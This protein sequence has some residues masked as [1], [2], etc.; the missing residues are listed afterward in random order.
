M[1]V[2][3][4]P[5]GRT[6]A[7]AGIGKT[8]TMALAALS[9]PMFATAACSGSD[10]AAEAETARGTLMTSAV[11]AAY[12]EAAAQQGRV[13]VL[14]YEARDYTRTDG[15]VTQK[16]AYVYLPYGYTPSQRYD[17]IYL[18]HGWTGTA[19]QYF[20]LPTMPQMKNLFDHMI[21]DGVCRPFIAVSPTWDKDNRAKG[22]NEST[23][24]IAVFSQEYEH[25]LIPAIESHYST[26]AASTD[27]AGIEASRSHRAFGGF[28]LG[29]ITTWY[30]FEQA[31]SLQR[32]FLPMSGDNWHVAMFGGATRPT[33]TAAFLATVVDA[34]PFKSDF[35]VWH[36]VGSN[37]SRYAQS[38]NQAQ[39][40]MQLPEFGPEV[41]SYHERE[42]G[43]HDFYSVWEF[44]YNALPAFFPLHAE[45]STG[46]GRTP[47]ADGQSRR[48]AY[49]LDGR[50]ATPH[51]GAGVYVV[52]GRK[53]KF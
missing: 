8:L 16:P 19:E 50:R 47:Q 11:P 25:D 17:I 21:A 46:V 4:K 23:R 24:E 28:S 9:L 12:F 32:Y 2:E 15:A 51:D 44:C 31:F 42:G 35:H 41:Y 29:A 6:A 26:Y 27:R 49:T 13:E 20:G 10:A 34:S 30:V 43:Q 38:H 7:H 45:R 1:K 39:A 22:W 18:L 36:G 3:R 52:N 48:T 37:D 40:M 53:L 5:T 14:T 33:E